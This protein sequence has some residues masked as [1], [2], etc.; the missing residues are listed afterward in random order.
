MSTSTPKTTSR[1]KVFTI[2]AALQDIFLLDRDDFLAGQLNR[3][4]VFAKLEIGTKVD[5]DQI[6][7][8]I[9][10]GGINSAVTLARAG[11]PTY[12]LGCISNDPAGQLVRQ[13]CRR[14]NINLQFL[15]TDQQLSTGCS[16][17]LLDEK[18]GERTIL[19]H[20]GVAGQAPAHIQS[21]L[22]QIQPDWIYLTTLQGNYPSLQQIFH[23]AQKLNTKIIFNP[24]KKELANPQKLLKI[25]TG[26][27]V[28]ILNHTEAI[29]LAMAIPHSSI[30]QLSE[31]SRLE[32]LNLLTKLKKYANIVIITTGKTG[33]VVSHV[34]PEDPK[35][36]H[37]Y[38][39]GLYDDVLV[40]DTTGAG[41]AFGSGFLA[42]YLE[43]QNLGQALAFASANA[44]A[45][46]QNI[47]ANQ[48][49]L[50]LKNTKLHDFPLIKL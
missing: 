36:T 24:G 32:P 13:L 23:F 50:Y 28:L 46:I 11:F 49:A 4:P 20:R 22:D 5:I 45:V 7:Y 47:G 8:S 48:N 38:R 44:T 15:T 3:R 12:F 21:A 37:F 29:E 41:D 33:G 27:E 18:T 16:V 6:I 40:R 10:G 26:L 1:P 39:F 17:I 2:G 35:Q 25:I 9:G 14:E 19:T 43:V 42:K 30:D 34:D 31:V